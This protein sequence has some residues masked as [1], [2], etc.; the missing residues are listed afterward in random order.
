MYVLICSFIYFF[1]YLFVHLFCIRLCV[2]AERERER[3]TNRAKTRA[4][5]AR[6]TGR[7]RKHRA[8]RSILWS[9]Y[10]KTLTTC[11]EHRRLAPTSTELSALALRH[12][13]HCE[14][15]GVGCDHKSSFKG[16]YKRTGFPAVPCMPNPRLKPKV[17]N[18]IRN[19]QSSA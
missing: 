19:F 10:V 17:Y 3:E 9:D 6:N 12:L 15:S 2:F 18:Q 4:T 14:C 13:Q 11:K 5:C 7:S 16:F 1:T 8:Q